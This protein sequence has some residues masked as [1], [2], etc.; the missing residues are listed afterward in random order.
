MPETPHQPDFETESIPEPPSLPGGKI[1]PQSPR[2]ALQS[3][4]GVAA[5]CLY[6]LVLAA[7]VILG[8]VNGHHYPT[9]FLVFPA[10]FIAASFGLLMLLRWAWALAL[11]AVFLLTA[12]NLWIFSSA[13]QFAGLVQGLLNLVFFLYLIR[14][15][16]RSRLR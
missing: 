11:S 1:P 5:I 2:N 4:P 9:L 16:V 13:H 10:A 8:V 12:Y 15:E 3:I 7:V 6:L 14:P